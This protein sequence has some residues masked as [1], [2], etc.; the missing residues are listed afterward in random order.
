MK[1][2]TDVGAKM[3]TQKGK[4]K[5]TETRHTSK[6]SQGKRR[7]RPW[8]AHQ[9][10]AERDTKPLT[11]TFTPMANIPSPINLTPLSACLNGQSME[12]ELPGENPHRHRENMQTPQRKPPV[13]WWM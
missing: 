8:I 9:F 1:D 7:S 5:N 4:K 6:Q 11:L 3:R 13:M 10:I 12:A 2:T